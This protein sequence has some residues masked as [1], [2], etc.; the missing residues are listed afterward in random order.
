MQENEIR[1]IAKRITQLWIQSNHRLR[2]HRPQL[3]HEQQRHQGEM[4]NRL[5]HEC[6]HVRRYEDW[7]LQEK[8]RSIVPVDR[9]HEEA[10]KEVQECTD[11]KES[12]EDILLRRL[13]RWFK[14]EFFQWV[15]EPPCE[16]CQV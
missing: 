8:A 11:S 2:K 3:S 16:K 12:F 10:R 6:Q 13:V 4:T 7:D 14:N 5:R 1:E 15:N 9:L